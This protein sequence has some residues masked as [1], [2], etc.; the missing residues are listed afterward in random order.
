MKNKFTF[1]WLLLSVVL[2]IAG[3][4]QS[5]WASE[6]HFSYITSTESWS[7]TNITYS[8][9]APANNVYDEYCA[10]LWIENGTYFAF[11]SQRNNS[12]TSGVYRPDKDN[13]RDISGSTGFGAGQWDGSKS[14]HYTG[15]SGLVKVN[16]AQSSEN[17]TSREWGPYIWVEESQETA[18]LNGI[19]IM[20]YFGSSYSSTW[21]Y[22][23]TGSENPSAA[24]QQYWVLADV[25]KSNVTTHYTVAYAAAACDYYISNSST[26]GGKLFS[27]DS[28]ATAGCLL[29]LGNKNYKYAGVLPSFS[30]TS[31]SVPYGTTESGVAATAS[32]SVIGNAQTI[33][34]YYQPSGGSTWTRFNPND[35]SDLAAGTYTVAALGWDGHILVKSSNTCTLTITA[36]TI[37]L[38]ANSGTAGSKTSFSTKLN[39]ATTNLSSGEFPTRSSYGF[40]G[41][42]TKDGSG[43]FVTKVIDAYGAWRANV[44]DYTDSDGKWICTSNSTL[45]ARWLA[46]GYYLVGDFN[47][48]TADASYLFS[49]SPL[50]VEID[51]DKDD[52]SGA[53]YLTEIKIRKVV[54]N[55]S[56]ACSDVWSGYASSGEHLGKGKTPKAISSD[57]SNNLYLEVYNSGK[58]TFTL[59]ETSGAASSIAVD[60]PVINQ[61]QIY[62][63]DPTDATHT[64][65]FDLSGPSSIYTKSLTLNAETKYRFKIVYN[66]DFY[67]FKTGASGSENSSN[68]GSYPMTSDNCTDWRMY[69]GAS[70]SDAGQDSYITTTLSGTYTFNFNSNNSGNTTLSVVYPSMPT[71]TGSLSLAVTGYAGGSGTSSDPYLVFSGRTLTC[72]GTHTS[73]PS[74]DSHLQYTFYQDETKKQTKASTESSPLSYSHSVGTTVSSSTTYQLKV[75]AYYEY[76]PSGCKVEGDKIYSGIIYYKVIS[77]PSVTLT[78]SPNPLNNGSTATLT[79]TVNNYMAYSTQKV[80]FTFKET[81]NSGTQIGS[82]Q[83]ISATVATTTA[84]QTVTP[85]YATSH[86]Y[87]VSITFLGCTKT[88]TC[89]LTMQ[90]VPELTT[91]TAANIADMSAT[92]G[93]NVSDYGNSTMTDYGVYYSTNSSLSSGNATT[94]GNQYQTGTS[95]ASTGAFSSLVTGLLPNTTYYYIAYAT[96]SAGTGWGT[97]QS[98]TTTNSNDRIVIRAQLPSSLYQENAID[99]IHWKEVNLY[100][101]VSGSDGEIYSG[102]TATAGTWVKEN[103]Y[104]YEFILPTTIT[105]PF[106]FIFYSH[107]RD[108]SR[109]ALKSMNVTDVSESGCYIISTD[110]GGYGDDQYKHYVNATENCALY[111]RVTSTVDE[112]VNGTAQTYYSNTMKNDGDI[113]SFFLPTTAKQNLKLQ[114]H[115]GYEWVDAKPLSSHTMTTGNVVTAEFNFTDKT[116]KDASFADYTGDYYIRTDGAT[117]GWSNYANSTYDNGMTYFDNSDANGYHYYWTKNVAK[118]STVNVK[119][120][121]ANQYCSTITNALDA[122]IYTNGS[123]QVIGNTYGVNLRFGYEPSTNKLN[124]AML[125]GS[126][127]NDFL[128]IISYKTAYLYKTDGSTDLYNLG[129]VA[130]TKFSDKGNWVYQ[131]NVKAYP[132]AQGGVQ[133]KFNSQTQTLIE[134]NSYLIGNAESSK[135]STQYELQLVYDFKTNKL[136]CAWVAGEVGNNQINLLTDMLIVRHAQDPG[137]QVTYGADGSLTNVE[138][139]FCAIE[140][141][142]DTMTSR[143]RISANDAAYTASDRRYC[144]LYISPSRLM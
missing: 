93:G 138:K 139:A 105:T 52:F 134:T 90:K 87:F 86:T 97:V 96:N 78:I 58:Y 141:K 12:G 109:S 69:N 83:S 70:D 33:Y 35:V 103:N 112:T 5:V 82:T 59:M 28:A 36:T 56:S 73:A 46:V 126:T 117:G 133:A 143:T 68:N 94:I 17:G 22:L 61:V 30:E 10:Y 111:Y 71:V 116:L 107:T 38:N 144:D 101:W 120:Q 2:S 81:N 7:S 51:L 54:A 121:V 8:L 89:T 85:S 74:A 132:G 55:S 80:S 98:F 37:T 57:G 104:W 23:K 91:T 108:D 3:I 122:D 31:V 11:N 60:V 84:T 13:D 113:V 88:T 44:A 136:M 131:L 53:S 75:G 137:V 72:T 50:K 6:P 48:W 26:W 102:C 127:D 130:D 24:N 32:T 67:S 14:W 20:F 110:Q 34:Y 41:Y 18:I 65:N 49:G 27:S 79:A 95:Q 21:L 125:K 106:N 47:N 142:R 128:N 77:E 29:S 43:N 63:A 118:N 114:H 62:G 99:G 123:C 76:G 25:T 45:Y 39:T 115:N 40:D 1:K 4:N 15:A 100:W 119:G 64:G 124:R 42:W 129:A 92:L 140:F 9:V 19:K 16:A 135:G 66:S